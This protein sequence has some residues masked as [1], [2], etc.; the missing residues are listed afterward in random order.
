MC[1]ARRRGPGRSSALCV[2]WPRRRRRSTRGEYPRPSIQNTAHIKACRQNDRLS[3]ATKAEKKLCSQN[4][5][6][7]QQSSKANRLLFSM[8]SRT[9]ACR[10]RLV[11]MATQSETHRIYTTRSNTSNCWTFVAGKHKSQ[12][13][14]TTL[15]LVGSI[16][17]Q[18]GIWS[19]AASRT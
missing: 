17:F 10:R 16:P 12:G 18:Q 1:D 4:V 5:R 19:W 11:W 13:L 15:W 2:H 14:C 6:T 7:V 9:H 8:T 3:E